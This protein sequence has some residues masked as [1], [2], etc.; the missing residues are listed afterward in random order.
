MRQLG[1]RR[2]VGGSYS[3]GYRSLCRRVVGPA[4]VVVVVVVVGGVRWKWKW[5]MKY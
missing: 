4:S 1:R 5:K 2:R 3:L